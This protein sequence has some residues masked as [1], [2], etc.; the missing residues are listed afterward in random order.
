MSIEFIEDCE[1]YQLGDHLWSGGY[2]TWKTIYEAD[3]E[4][5]LEEYIKEVFSCGTPTITEINDLLWFESSSVFEAC[6]LDEDGEPLV[7]FEDDGEITEKYLTYLKENFEEEANTYLSFEV[8]EV[9]KVETNSSHTYGKG[10]FTTM[11]LSFTNESLNPN[12]ISEEEFN[13]IINKLQGYKKE[14]TTSNGELY[15]LFEVEVDTS[16]SYKELKELNQE[17]SMHINIKVVG[18]ILDTDINSISDFMDEV[19]NLIEGNLVEN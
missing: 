1:V 3:K 5:E 14:D 16:L 2:D 13:T 19:Y 4:D 9:G 11:E 18:R 8:E 10:N 12:D 7:N 17:P 15:S 6:G